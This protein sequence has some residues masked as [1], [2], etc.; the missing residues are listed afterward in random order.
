M[1]WSARSSS[2]EFKSRNAELPLSRLLFAS[3]Q[4]GDVIVEGERIT[5]TCEHRGARRR[6]CRPRGRLDLRTSTTRSRTSSRSRTSL[7]AST[8]SRH[9]EPVGLS[10][11]AELQPLAASTSGSRWRRRWRRAMLLLGVVLLVVVGG[12]AVWSS[13][14]VRVPPDLST[15]SPRRRAPLRDMSGDA[16][17]EYFS[18]GITRT[19]SRLSKSPGVVIARNSVSRTR[20]RRSIRSVSRSWRALRPGGQRSQGRESGPDHRPARRRHT[21]TTCGRSVMTGI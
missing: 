3:H 13:P 20:A 10:G 17:Q 2:S 14:S 7:S 5:A 18:D 12:V 16:G 4:P 9:P 21:G 15:T 6:P 19:S 11:P 8:S 1:R